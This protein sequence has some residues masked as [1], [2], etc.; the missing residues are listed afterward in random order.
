MTPLTNG[1]TIE[2]LST[3]CIWFLARFDGLLTVEQLET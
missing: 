2:L 3:W 1:C